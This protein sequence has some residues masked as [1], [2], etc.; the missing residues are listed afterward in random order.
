MLI[1]YVWKSNYKLSK[2][3]DKYIRLMDDIGG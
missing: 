3:I 2:L 1:V